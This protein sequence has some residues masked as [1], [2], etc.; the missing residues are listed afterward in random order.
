VKI[1]RIQHDGAPVTAIVDGDTVRRLPGVS[2]LDLLAAEPDQ[3]DRLAGRA[4]EEVALADARLLA[5][6]V[7][8]SIRDFSVF[9]QHVEGAQ[10]LFA[11]PDATVP[12]AWAERPA[13][14]FSN[15]SSLFG[16]DDE[17]AVPPECELLDLELEVGAVI[18]RTGRNVSVAEAGSYI[19]GYTL[20]NDWSARDIAA[21]ETRLPFGFHKT[22]DFANTLGPWIVTADE[23]E[24][25]RSGDRL[26]LAMK[27]SINGKPL[28]DGDTLA[29]MAWSY[30]ELVAFSAQGATIAAG[31]VIASGTCGNG[32]LM[33]L[34]GRAQRHEPPPLKPGDEV[35]I[36]VEAIGTLT[37]TIVGTD[38]APLNLPPARRRVKA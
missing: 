18:G 34:W 30:E 29:S 15:P 19:A 22:K 7:P 21:R 14:Y 26:D 4:T 12:E 2:V 25:H 16:P 32:C 31:D 23:L 27:A 10:M 11:G 38:V 36:E 24:P 5:P 1:A 9:E 20:L 33:E 28:N 17:I 8:P 13:F 3:R 6:I 35:T 37:N